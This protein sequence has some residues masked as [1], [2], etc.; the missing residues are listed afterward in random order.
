[1]DAK[2]RE[3]RLRR[4]AQRQRLMLMKSRRRDRLAADFG[5]YMVI[6]EDGRPVAGGSPAFSLDLDGVE[7]FLTKK[8][9]G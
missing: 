9:T 2:V 4:M 3:N 7:R 1:M 5:G 8:R 6:D